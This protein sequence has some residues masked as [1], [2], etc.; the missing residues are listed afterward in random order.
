MWMLSLKNP[1]LRKTRSDVNIENQW[2][3]KSEGQPGI[4]PYLTR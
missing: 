1:T 2:F 3:H 4:T